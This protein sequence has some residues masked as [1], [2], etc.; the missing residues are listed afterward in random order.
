MPD[1]EQLK[2]SYSTAPSVTSRVP[3]ELS[4]FIVDVDKN[5]RHRHYRY[6]DSQWGTWDT[7]GTGFRSAPAAFAIT[8]DRMDIFGVKDDGAL[9]HRAWVTKQL[10]LEWENFGGPF[11]EIVSVEKFTLD[12]LILVGRKADGSYEGRLY[13]WNRP[14]NESVWDS[15]G[16]A[17]AS[18]PAVTYY[19]DSDIRIFG[20]GLDGALLYQGFDITTGRWY[21]GP[22][23]WQTVAEV[24]KAV[25]EIKG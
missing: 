15:L 19:R 25:G 6:S 5:L 8:P 11:D 23:Q 21:P 12:S 4:L 16:G 2:G 3:G 20:I 10:G 7:I 14:A 24:P 22:R 1:F 17:F 9:Y 13:G 18:Q